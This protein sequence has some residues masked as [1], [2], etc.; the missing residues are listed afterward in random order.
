MK[1]LIVV[2]GLPGAGKSDFVTY[3][4]VQSWVCGDQ[5]ASAIPDNPKRPGEAGYQRRL[6]AM[7]RVREHARDGVPRICLEGVFSDMSVLAPLL[8]A[9]ELAEYRVVVIHVETDAPPETLAARNTHG[10][11]ARSILA[12]AEAWQPYMEAMYERHR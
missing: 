6:A 4:G 3:L 10:V 7:D 8:M 9:P 12:C 5:F 1:T 2:R 11:E